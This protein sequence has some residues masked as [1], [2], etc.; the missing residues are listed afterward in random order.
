MDR[1]ARGPH[2]G[3]GRYRGGA[4][5]PL[6]TSAFGQLLARVEA[7]V[8][9]GVL[10]GRYAEIRLTPGVPLDFYGRGIFAARNVPVTVRPT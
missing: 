1:A 2:V 10:L 6:V 4:A 9:V 3:A 5:V 8:A 7:R